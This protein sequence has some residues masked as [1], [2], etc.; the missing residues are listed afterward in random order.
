ME[1]EKEKKVKIGFNWKNL[2][3]LFGFTVIVIIL[4]SAVSYFA[5]KAQNKSMQD[6]QK[7]EVQKQELKIEDIVVGKGVIAKSGDTVTVNYLGTLTD[8]KKFDSSYDRNKPFTFKLGLGEV[9][10]GWDE[11]VSG[12]AVGGKRKL[13]IPSDKGYGEKGAG[14]T[15]PPNSTLIFEVELLEVK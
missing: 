5:G 11:G 10:Q 15:I 13:T 12:M 2:S 1:D 6:N 9:I 4:L 8:G 14:N 3:Y 7:A